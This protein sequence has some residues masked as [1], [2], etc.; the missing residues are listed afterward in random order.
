ML[1]LISGWK[2]LFAYARKAW[3][4]NRTTFGRSYEK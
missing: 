3:Q 4:D 2:N 1:N